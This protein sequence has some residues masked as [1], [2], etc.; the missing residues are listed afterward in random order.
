MDA[1]GWPKEGDFMSD[2]SHRRFRLHRHCDVEFG[3]EQ[4]A[5]FIIIVINQCGHTVSGLSLDADNDAFINGFNNVDSGNFNLQSSFPNNF[6]VFETSQCLGCGTTTDTVTLTAPN[7]GGIEDF[8]QT[9]ATATVTVTAPNGE[10][11]H[12]AWQ[13]PTWGQAGGSWSPPSPPWQHNQ[14][15][16][17]LFPNR[18]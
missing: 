13:P 6:A 5:T 17:N 7:R 18:R 16:F 1:S 3:D 12:Q 10:G 15:L 14:G 11:S 9:T 2:P 4:N 8:C